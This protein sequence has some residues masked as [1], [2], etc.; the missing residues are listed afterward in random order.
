MVVVVV[1]EEELPVVDF[2]HGQWPVF[3]CLYSVV[4]WTTSL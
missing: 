2:C 4:V 3:L 1:V